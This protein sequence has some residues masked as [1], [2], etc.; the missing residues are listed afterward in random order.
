MRRRRGRSYGLAEYREEKNS[1]DWSIRGGMPHFIGEE[2]VG[3]AGDQRSTQVTMKREKRMVGVD[4][5][6]QNVKSYSKGK[7]KKCERKL[8][9]PLLQSFEDCMA[10]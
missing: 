10:W 8:Q 1:F 4:F 6:S 5:D 3:G 7:V 2:T 9:P